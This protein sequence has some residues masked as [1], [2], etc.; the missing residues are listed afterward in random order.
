MND[1]VTVTPRK[2]ELHDNSQLKY[3]ILQGFYCLS[4]L[5]DKLTKLSIDCGL[6]PLCDK[7]LDSLQVDCRNSL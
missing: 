6:N 7:L 3:Y 2:T 4:G 5:Q 1:V